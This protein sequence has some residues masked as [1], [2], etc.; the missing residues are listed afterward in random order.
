VS[1]WT[2]LLGVQ[3][4]DTALDRLRHRRSTLPQRAAL[5]AAEQE[6]AKVDQ[7][8]AEVES[9]RSGLERRRAAL[10]DEVAGLEQKSG[11]V[12]RR[13][14]S[15]E[16]TATRELTAMVDQLDALKRRR[17]VLEDEE[18]ELM[19]D[20]EP[21]DAELATL[22][23][24]HAD[25]DQQV[26]GLRSEVA[27]I[28]AQ[29]DV[30]LAA[31]DEARRAAAEVVPSALLARYEKLRDRLGGIGAAPLVG[32]SCGGCH[33]AF[34]ATELDRIRHEPPDAMVTCD[35]CGRILVR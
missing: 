22:A 20:L 7:R 17:S 9:E 28:E 25:L 30:E 18:L 34:S 13:M 12:D 15:G 29:L 32:G 2:A 23:A 4:H 19:V 10:E 27:V 14:H 8:W 35:Q 16:V 3:E 26:A 6:L 24:Q 11:E 1:E 21:L 5:G 33:L 31:E